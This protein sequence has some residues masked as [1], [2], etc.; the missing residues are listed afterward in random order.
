MRYQPTALLTAALLIFA[1]CDSNA[2]TDQ[3]KPAEVKTE[4][5]EPTPFMTLMGLRT[6][7]KNFQQWALS[8]NDLANL[9]GLNPADTTDIKKALEEGLLDEMSFNMAGYVFESDSWTTEAPPT[10]CVTED[11][12]GTFKI[13]YKDGL[14][15]KFTLD[16]EALA[17]EL[18]NGYMGLDVCGPMLDSFRVDYDRNRMATYLKGTFSS[19]GNY[20]IKYSDYVFDDKG[21]WV[22]RR[23]TTEGNGITEELTEYRAYVY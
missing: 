9:S 19:G 21:N 13:E 5:S 20:S 12:A 7:V 22:K 2:K 14:P 23:K 15:V 10:G 16:G 4:S 17:E 3:S 18:E 1:A 8:K 6:P 11:F